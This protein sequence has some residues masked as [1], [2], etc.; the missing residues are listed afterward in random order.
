MA[1]C[2]SARLINRSRVRSNK[3]S[4]FYEPL[5]ARA[6][7]NLSIKGRSLRRNRTHT[8]SVYKVKLTVRIDIKSQR[9]FAIRFIIVNR[10]HLHLVVRE[11]FTCTYDHQFAVTI[12][13]NK[14][15]SYIFLRYYE[16]AAIYTRTKPH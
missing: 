8:E 9:G 4:R 1:E 5:C 13:K 11:S 10:V 16:V 3:A 12:C 15:L 7:D 2:N 6:V 14:I